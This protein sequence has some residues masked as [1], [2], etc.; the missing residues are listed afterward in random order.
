MVLSD[1]DEKYYHP[2][3]AAQSGGERVRVDEGWGARNASFL[4]KSNFNSTLIELNFNQDQHKFQART[5]QTW[6][7]RR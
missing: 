5:K 6:S 1:D 7:D 4:Y 3:E 2:R